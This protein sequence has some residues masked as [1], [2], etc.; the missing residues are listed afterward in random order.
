MGMLRF[1]AIA[2]LALAGCGISSDPITGDVDGGFPA[3]DGGVGKGGDAPSWDEIAD[4]AGCDVDLRCEEA[5]PEP[6]DLDCPAQPEAVPPRPPPADDL[7]A[8]GFVAT[9]ATLGFPGEAW[10]RLGTTEEPLV[11]V[12]EVTAGAAALAAYDAE[13]HVL[14]RSVPRADGLLALRVAAREGAAA[15]VLLRCVAARGGATVT[16]RRTPAAP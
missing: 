12:A 2:V 15:P 1:G 6:Q 16:V 14:A 10:W 3:P 13:G 4:Y 5:C 11:A 7:D 8:L 9:P